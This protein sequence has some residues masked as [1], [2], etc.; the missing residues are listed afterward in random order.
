MNECTVRRTTLDE[1]QATRADA[2]TVQT[3]AAGGRA[4]TSLGGVATAT[5]SKRH[6]QTVRRVGGLIL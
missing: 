5:V 4:G 6:L 1:G 2:R 3:A